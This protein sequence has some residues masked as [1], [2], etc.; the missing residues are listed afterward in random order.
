[1]KEGQ[2]TAIVPLTETTAELIPERTAQL[3]EKSFAENTLR[4]RRY[5][6]QKFDE[7]LRRRPISD[8]LLTQYITD[9]F[10]EGKAPGTISIAV[11]AVKWLL[12]YLNNGRQVELTRLRSET[13]LA[14]RGLPWENGYAERLIRTLKEEEV[15]LNGY[16]DIHE[17]RTRIR[18]PFITQVYHQKRPHSALDYLTPM[19]FE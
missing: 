15:H 10:N 12:K 3:V 5:A 16:E 14:Q 13:S 18:K 17:A 11:S 6:L 7:W 2:A 4:N 9:L 1:M 19:E 8:G